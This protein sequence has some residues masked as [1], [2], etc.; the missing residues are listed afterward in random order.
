MKLIH[1]TLGR[2]AVVVLV[3]MA[4]WS[5]FFYFQI[6]EEVH[7]ETDDRLKDYQKTII[8]QALRD[9]T[10][11][12]NHVDILTR[13]YVR[14]I[15]EKEGKHYREK[16]LTT[17]I[18]NEYEMDD[19]PVRV[20]KTAFRT[21]NGRYYELT[22]MTSTL[23]EDDILE[24]I[25]RSIVY[26]YLATVIGMLIVSHLVFRKSLRPFYRLMQW[27]D[28]FTV[29]RKN[30][31][32]ESNTRVTEFRR[33]NRAISEMAERNKTVFE[34][35]KQ[36]IENASHELQTPL[37]V[38]RNKLELLAE[39][40][41]CTEEQLKEIGE[42]HQ[43]IGRIIRLN[44]SLLLLS[45]IE[46][47]Q[48]TDTKDVIFNFLLRKTADDFRDIYVHRKLQIEI[49]EKGN[50]ECF[51]NEMLA[52]VLVTNLLKNAV[53]HSPDE[54]KVEVNIDT[55]EIVF[56]NDAVG[57]ALSKERIFRRFYHAGNKK[58]EST[59]LGLAIVKSITEIY[60]LEIIYEYD[61]RHNFKLR[62]PVVFN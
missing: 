19:E 16:F 12:R 42:I 57:G 33:L 24:S 18:L 38:C 56:S 26:L 10:L 47:R 11:L 54:A 58:T 50:F 25:F 31:I 1:Y 3:M 9:S 48:F 60:N 4:F 32:L 51:I 7:D 41:A 15:P 40:S 46:N 49:F 53:I 43:V 44:K 6:M 8:K 36:F 59:G 2:L 14:E 22:V 28:G 30:E 29:G 55:R 37:A 62:I 35:Q 23:E 34:E 21:D 61:G 52:E 13:Y 27:L 45:R 20:L 5:V 17:E 39:N